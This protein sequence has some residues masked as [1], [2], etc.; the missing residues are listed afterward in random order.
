[1]NGETEVVNVE[2]KLLCKDMD[3]ADVDIDRSP[4]HHCYHWAL[5]K[6]A[7]LDDH[8]AH[9]LTAVMLAQFICQV[10]KG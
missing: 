10:F 5:W 2:P 9:S 8:V 1:M 7:F 3:M 6:I 4:N